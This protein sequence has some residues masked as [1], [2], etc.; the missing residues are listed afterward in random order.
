MGVGTHRAD[1]SYSLEQLNIPS[2]CTN[3]NYGEGHKVLQGYYTCQ[4]CYLRLKRKKEAVANTEGKTKNKKG[5][6]KIE[7]PKYCVPC[8]E[9]CHKLQGHKGVR[10]VKKTFFSSA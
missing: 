5:E 9:I 8:G 7:Q 2:L 3:I 6:I 10:F 4:Q 1:L